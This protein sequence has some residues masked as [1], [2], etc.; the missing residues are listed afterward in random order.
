MRDHKDIDIRLHTI[1][2][3]LHEATQKDS[4]SPDSY[5]LAGYYRALEWV[6]DL[7]IL[8]KDILEKK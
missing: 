1:A 8:V 4:A 5:Y 3:K 7:P 6:L 2:E